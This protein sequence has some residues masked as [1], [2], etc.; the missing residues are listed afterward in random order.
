MRK[1]AGWHLVAAAIA[2][3]AQLLLFAPPSFAQSSP[4]AFTTGYRYD[5]GGRVTGVISPDPD[6]TG[7]IRYAAVRNTY[8]TQG[9]PVTIETGELSAWQSEAVAPTNWTGFTVFRTETRTY[10]DWGRPTRTNQTSGGTTYAVT[11]MSYDAHGRLDCTAVRMN[12][13]AFGSLP[14]S[15]CTLGAEGSQGKDRITRSEYDALNRVTRVM[16][17]YGAPLQQDYARYEYDGGGNQTAITDANSNR[18]ERDFDGFGHLSRIEFPS[19]TTA[20]Q[21]NTADYESY[22]YDP[23]GNRTQLRKRDGQ[24]I[25][26][27]YDA[28]NRVTAQDVGGAATAEDVFYGYDLRSLRTYARFASASGEG[29]TEAYDGFG[30]RLSSTTN[31]GGVARQLTHTYDADGNRTRVDYPGGVSFTYEYD[32]LDRMTRALENGA[33]ELVRIAYDNQD[34]RSSLVRANGAGA[35]TT[36]GYDPIS[37]PSN[38]AHDLVGTG[39][40]LSF[41]F[42]YNPASQAISRSITSNNA[43]YSYAPAAASPVSYVHNGLN[44][45]TS[46][47]GTAFGYDANGNLTSDGATTFGYDVGNRLRTATGARNATLSYDPLGRLYQTV[48]GGVTTRFLYDGDALVAEYDA[49]G[50]VLR[51]YVH[52]A[53]IDEPWVWYEGASVVSA[54]RRFLH[55]D[56]QGSIV[57]VSDNSGALVGANAYDP[58]GVPASSNLGRFQYTGQI[59]LPELALYHYKARIYS[60]TLGRFLQTDPVGYEDELNWY[61]YVGNDP[62]NAT[63]PSG[64]C[65][66]RW[67]SFCDVD[68]ETDEDEIV[69][70]AN[71]CAGPA[72]VVCLAAVAST[73]AVLAAVEYAARRL[74]E[75]FNNSNDNDN[76]SAPPAPPP[77]DTAGTPQGPDDPNGETPQQQAARV[78]GQLGYSETREFGRL[79]GQQA[80]RRGNTVI[81]R[82]VGERGVGGHRGGYWKRFEVRGGRLHRVGSYNHDLTVRVGP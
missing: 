4:S 10:D 67:S 26:Y 54:A 20:G 75:I 81:S 52:G 8:N 25:N 16:R 74:G 79:H 18:T 37:R 60:A 47:A 15:A 76:S 31:V 5:V 35:A 55:P 78:A 70:T 58:Y 36:Y 14:S 57:S 72:A 69:V 38:L 49:S 42:T 43:A 68:F 30:R 39:S 6:G 53:G 56:H 2:L 33:S 46:V 80:F 40:D 82:D 63:D 48:S 71:A 17:A 44:Q 13:A 41:A 27:S 28:L 1:N 3:A 61:A 34:R 19:P 64:Q 11:Q 73:I 24:L 32:G 45:Y 77:A 22:Q 62:L 59:W 9:M 29:L 50:T 66:K 7:S 21:V 65:L 12:S 51:R 23:N